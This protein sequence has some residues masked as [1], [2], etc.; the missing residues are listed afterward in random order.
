MKPDKSKIFPAPLKPGDKIAIL[1]PAGRINPDFVNGAVEVLRAKGWNP[2]VYPNALGRHGSYSGSVSQRLGDLEKALLNPEIR[3]IVC[4]RGG[5]GAVH[6]LEQL[7]SLPFEKDPKWIVG[8]SDISAL[9]AL[10]ASKDI[11]SIHGPMTKDITRGGPDDADNDLLFRILAGEKPEETFP[12]STYDRP[13]MAMGTL[14]GGNLSVLAQLI[15]TPFN[16]LNP[17]TILF[18]EDVEEPIYK[19]ER[20]LYQLRLAGILPELRGLIVGQFTG[21]KANDNYR[22]MEEMIKDMVEPYT[23]PVAMNVPIGHV[24]HNIPLISGAFVTLRVT[25]GENNSIVYW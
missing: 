25:M 18:M 17:D 3:A 16:V 10:M 11:V 24:D 13:G 21:Y 4:S 7:D 12:S 1:S 5:Y 6:L 23:Y 19:I 8:F 20:I 14:L 9:H 2:V 22:K 15:G